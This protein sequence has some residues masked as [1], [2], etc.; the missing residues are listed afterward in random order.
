MIESLYFNT[1]NKSPYHP[2]ICIWAGLSEY[3]HPNWATGKVAE[4]D[5]QGLATLEP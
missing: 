5:T 1:I 3:S 2:Q 4:N